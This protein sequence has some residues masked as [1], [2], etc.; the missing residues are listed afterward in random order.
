MPLIGN[1]H[2]TDDLV[3]RHRVR[4][5]NAGQA[6]LAH[7]EHVEFIDFSEKMLMPDGSLVE[8]LYA[9]D[10]LHLSPA[11]YKLWSREMDLVLSGMLN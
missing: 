10:K 4:A 5:I 2:L 9:G 7:G 8:N 3:H 11:G 6:K 1:T